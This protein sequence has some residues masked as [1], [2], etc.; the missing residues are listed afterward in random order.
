MSFA[1][2]AARMNVS[3]L[4]LYL[5]FP[6]I[7]LGVA[8]L[9]PGK[10]SLLKGVCI[11]LAYFS[12]ILLDGAICGANPAGMAADTISGKDT[13]PFGLAF[14]IISIWAFA[15]VGLGGKSKPDSSR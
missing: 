6:A 12:L 1:L 4:F 9:A 15:L 14:V 2:T 5:V 10:I 8:T 11:A 13:S 3:I 7:F